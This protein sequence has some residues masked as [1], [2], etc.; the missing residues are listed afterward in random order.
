MDDFCEKSA[1]SIHNF[2]R[3]YIKNVDGRE[4]RETFTCLDKKEK[5]GSK[6]KFKRYIWMVCSF[7]LFIYIAINIRRDVLLV[8][9]TSLGRLFIK[10]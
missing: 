6:I 3:L 9:R 7:I 8:S 1:D 10:R 2:A 4:Y 5:N